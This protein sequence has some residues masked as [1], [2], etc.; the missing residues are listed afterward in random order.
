MTDSGYNRPSEPDQ[1]ETAAALDRN[2]P[3]GLVLAATILAGFFML[4]GFFAF[5]GGWSSV[6]DS[7]DDLGLQLLAV[8]QGAMPFF[9]A[10]GLFWLLAEYKTA[11]KD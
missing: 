4:V 8:G 11:H 9:I 10:S 7:T 2:V 5:I 3:K 1:S 6:T